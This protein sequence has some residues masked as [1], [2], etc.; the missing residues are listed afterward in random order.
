MKEEYIIN[1]LTELPKYHYVTI[2]YMSRLLNS[3]LSN[4]GKK[5]HYCERCLHAF[6]TEDKLD[7]HEVDCSRINKCRID[8]PKEENKILKFKDYTQN[9]KVPYVIYADFECLLKE[10]SNEKTFQL[11]EAYSIGFYVK[12]SFDENRSYYRSYRKLSFDEKAPSEWFVSELKIIAD[13]LEAMYKKP[14]PLR[15]TDLEELNF[16]RAIICHICHRC[17]K[18][19]ET[20]VRDHCHLTG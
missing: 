14:L 15:L 11:H 1:N 4:S 9:E 12:C 6:Y 5:A 18:D 17:F 2:K 13:E 19:K 10:T 16:Q 3:Q 8:L 20:R 7:A